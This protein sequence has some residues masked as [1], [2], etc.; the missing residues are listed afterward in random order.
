MQ[1]FFPVNKNLIK[2]KEFWEGL[3]QKTLKTTKCHNNHVHW[4]PRTF[5]NVCYTSE[6]DWIDLPLEG[7][8]KQWTEVNA[9]PE[10]FPKSYLVGILELEPRYIRIFGKILNTDLKDLEVDKK[11]TIEFESI[12]NEWFF[13]F[14]G[15]S[16]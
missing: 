13:Y 16:N 15:K 3:K 9:P 14:K 7:I 6:L 2:T 10:G 5:C 4:P 12:E 8:L 1:E 11:L